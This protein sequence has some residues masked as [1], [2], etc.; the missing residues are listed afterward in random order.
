MNWCYRIFAVFMAGSVV[1]GAV[2]VNAQTTSAVISPAAACKALANVDF[3]GV[4]D[5]PTQIVEAKLIEAKGVVP[6]YCL[7]KGYISSTVGI[8]LQLPVANWNGKFL[9]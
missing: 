5:A 1:M 3:S 4:Q 6:M 9:E 8:E 2:R 7:A